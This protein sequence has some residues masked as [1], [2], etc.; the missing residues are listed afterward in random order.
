LSHAFKDSRLVF[1]ELRQ[2][3]ESLFQKPKQK[4]EVKLWIVGQ[5]KADVFALQFDRIKNGSTAAGPRRDDGR[6]GAGSTSPTIASAALV[7]SRVVGHPVEVGRKY[8]R[9]PSPACSASRKR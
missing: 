7:Y 5:R 2:H 6:A 1:S 3:L 9:G 8:D 4:H